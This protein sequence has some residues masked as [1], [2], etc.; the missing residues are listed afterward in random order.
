MALPWKS[1][2][3]E[4]TRNADLWNMADEL[5]KEAWHLLQQA[6][7]IDN[8]LLSTPKPLLRGLVILVTPIEQIRFNLKKG[9]S[10]LP[11]SASLLLH[12][13][14]ECSVAS[15]LS[16]DGTQYLSVECPIVGPWQGNANP[17]GSTSVPVKK[18]L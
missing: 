7:L 16:L 12:K 2:E 5:S 18:L 10:Y 14:M 15:Q 1:K 4:V 6:E 9:H 3:T 17:H 11:S 8:P 13:M